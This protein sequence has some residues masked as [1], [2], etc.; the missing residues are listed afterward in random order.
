VGSVCVMYGFFFLILFVLPT[1]HVA[2]RVLCAVSALACVAF[3]GL[4]GLSFLVFAA[5]AGHALLG[6]NGERAATLLGAGFIALA[7]VRNYR[8]CRN[9]NCNHH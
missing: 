3:A 8:L 7:H 1:Y 4:A 5:F 6:E 9:L 2:V